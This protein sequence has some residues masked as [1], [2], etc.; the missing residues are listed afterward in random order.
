MFQLSLTWSKR[1]YG[2]DAD[3]EASI[4]RDMHRLKCNAAKHCGHLA[5]DWSNCVDQK[6]LEFASCV[7][8]KVPPFRLPHD[9]RVLIR[10]ILQLF[11][12]VWRSEFCNFPPTGTFL[13][14][15]QRNSQSI[16]HIPTRRPSMEIIKP[17]VA[18]NKSAASLRHNY[19]HGRS[20][21]K[22]FNIY[23]WSVHRCGRKW[24]VGAATPMNILYWKHFAFA[25]VPCIGRS[26]SA[27]V[28]VL[29]SM[30][31]I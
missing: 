18:N 1:L 15:R 7:T 11:K 27:A 2:S 23:I 24:A 5:I 4:F 31:W 16:Q 25:S 13:S 21:N 29:F 9:Y 19:S 28:C 20:N 8:C 14:E 30:L 12:W 17:I 3:Y 10:T 26:Y 22:T 6:Q